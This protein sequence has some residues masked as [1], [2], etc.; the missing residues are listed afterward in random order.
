[1]LLV[2][3]FG[4][5]EENAVEIFHQYVVLFFLNVEFQVFSGKIIMW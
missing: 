3:R 5:V 4:L 1:M 2:S